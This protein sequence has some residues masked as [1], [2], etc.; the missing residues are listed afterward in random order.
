MVEGSGGQCDRRKNKV[1]KW[2]E[3]G[4]N[5]IDVIYKGVGLPVFMKRGSV[6]TE[7]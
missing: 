4:R 6:L 1:F 3:S 7:E 2:F 5:L